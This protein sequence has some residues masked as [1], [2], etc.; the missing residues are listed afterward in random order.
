MPGFVRYHGGDCRSRIQTDVPQR[1][2]HSIQRQSTGCLGVL[3]LRENDVLL[4]LDETGPSTLEMQVETLAMLEVEVQHLQHLAQ[5]RT[6]ATELREEASGKSADARTGG[7]QNSV[8]GI[9]RIVPAKL[10]A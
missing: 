10:E 7:L 6:N 2:Q 1:S 3:K 9:C 8:S 5:S 4:A